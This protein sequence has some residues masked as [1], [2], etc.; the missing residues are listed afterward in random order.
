[1][2]ESDRISM[3]ATQSDRATHADDVTSGRY[4]WYALTITVSTALLVLIFVTQYHLFPH[5]EGQFAEGAVRVLRGEL[6][7]RDFDEMYSGGVTYY[8]A[9]MFRIFESSFYTLRAAV[10]L[11]SLPAIA[12]MFDLLYRLLGRPFDAGGFTLVAFVV[13]LGMMHAPHCNVY[14]ANLAIIGLWAAARA[15]LSTSRLEHL[16]M[17]ACLGLT[18]GLSLTCKITGLYAVAAGGVAVAL[19]NIRTDRAAR[20][21]RV[22]Q[23]IGCLIALS[24]TALIFKLLSASPTLDVMLFFGVPALLTLAG[25]VVVSRRLAT[26]GFLDDLAL[27]VATAAIPVAIFVAFF[28]SQGAAEDLYRGLIEL[29]QKRVNSRAMLAP[30]SPAT[31]LLGMTFAAAFFPWRVR[32]AELFRGLGLLAFAVIA[33]LA[34]LVEAGGGVIDERLIAFYD[35][36]R[37]FPLFASTAF[38]TGLAT[39]RTGPTQ[40]DVL[41]ALAL[42]F[43]VFFQLHQFPFAQPVYYLYVW[44]IALVAAAALSTHAEQEPVASDV[45]AG[46]S[47]LAPVTA[48]RIALFA[49]AA[50]FMVRCGADGVQYEFRDPDDNQ[51]R[52]YRTLSGLKVWPEVAARYDGIAEAVARVPKDRTI[53]A[54]PDS[55]EIYFLTGR[56]NPTR[57]MYDFFAEPDS[58]PLNSPE[59]PRE[60]G[61]VII[62]RAPAFSDP[63]DTIRGIAD[64]EELEESLRTS[65]FTVLTERGA[66]RQT[67][68]IASQRP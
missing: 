28:A 2:R 22:G 49:V 45:V 57:L 13:S 21:Q 15:S 53:L 5:D 3:P 24:G 66:H 16:L 19:V 29:P 36:L 56:E 52:G 7:H 9:L 6:P 12:A 55:P 20:G 62:N 61:A 1:M 38:L 50:F 48:G 17:V 10:V 39:K 30:P 23:S 65:R 44:P 63:W 64:A 11:A 35:A 47:L 68:K 41:L 54:G 18:A 51:P 25:I 27:F 8:H 40:R 14:L 43:L 46:R 60:I 42:A 59:R 33:W 31:A 4:P 37:W 58:H 34:S 32:G 67:T 26:R